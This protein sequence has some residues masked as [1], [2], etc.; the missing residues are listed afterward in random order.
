LLFQVETSVWQYR[1]GP[2]ETD[3]QGLHTKTVGLHFQIQNEHFANNGGGV[4][5]RMEIRCTSTVGGSTRHKS[6]FPTLARPLTSDKLAQEGFRNSAGK[7]LLRK[8]SAEILGDENLI[9]DGEKVQLARKYTKLIN[10]SL[11]VS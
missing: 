7:I 8:R 10:C 1:E 9:R 5:P 11:N 6:V 4:T 3:A 2:D